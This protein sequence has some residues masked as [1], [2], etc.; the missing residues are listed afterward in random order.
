MTP[1]KTGDNYARIKTDFHR[2]GRRRDW[3]NTALQ[4]WRVRIAPHANVEF[5]SEHV[6]N[7]RRR[8]SRNWRPGRAGGTSRSVL[9]LDSAASVHRIARWLHHV[10]GV[11]V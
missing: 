10:L 8:L 5:S 6:F 9:A 1:V 4:T 11:R 2:R 7:K 3:L